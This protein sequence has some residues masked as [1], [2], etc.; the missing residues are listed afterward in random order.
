MEIRIGGLNEE[1]VEEIT[2][3]GLTNTQCLF[4]KPHESLLL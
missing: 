2:W 1:G 4:E 3:Q